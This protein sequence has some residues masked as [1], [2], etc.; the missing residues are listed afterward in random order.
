ML[1]KIKNIDDVKL[2]ANQLLNEGVNFHCDEDF[3]NYI[4]SETNRKTY[5]KQ[6]ADFR[7]RLMNESFRICDKNGED[8]Y[9]IMGS[10]LTK[11]LFPS[12]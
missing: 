9:E 8:I 11:Q 1:R 6:K 4:N 12:N 10:V 2:F 7:N 3:N 5:S